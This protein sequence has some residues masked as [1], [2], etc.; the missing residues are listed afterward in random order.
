[1]SNLP[2]CL[3]GCLINCL[4]SDDLTPFHQKEAWRF[5]WRWRHKCPESD[6]AIKNNQ[7]L[8]FVLRRKENAAWGDWLVDV[9]PVANLLSRVV[10]FTSCSCL[11]PWKL[12]NTAHFYTIF[13]LHFPW[14][15]TVCLVWTFLELNTK[16]RC[17]RDKVDGWMRSFLLLLS[18]IHHEGFWLKRLAGHQ[19]ELTKMRSYA[20][21]GEASS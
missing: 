8:L 2:P 9:T 13:P 12:H 21:G 20:G 16:S 5:V 10:V 14:C 18:A 15:L 17:E 19:P 1:M 4:Q 7:Q 11:T 6:N 3:D